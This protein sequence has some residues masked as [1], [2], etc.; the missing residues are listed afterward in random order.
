M[1][2]THDS[3]FILAS[4]QMLDS[5]LRDPRVDE[6][7]SDLIDSIG[8]FVCVASVCEWKAGER[9]RCVNRRPK[10]STWSL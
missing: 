6:W 4:D 1:H 5:D 2:C 3:L 7:L 8:K 10:D 9:Q